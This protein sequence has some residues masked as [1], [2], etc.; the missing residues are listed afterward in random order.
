MEAKASGDVPFKTR[1]TYSHV[2]RIAAFLEQGRK[3]PDNG[4]DRH[5]PKRGGKHIPFSFQSLPSYQPTVC[6]IERFQSRDP[7]R[8]STREHGFQKSRGSQRTDRAKDKLTLQYIGDAD[9]SR[10]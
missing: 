1:D 4:P 6:R 7:C 8:Q 10:W 3:S 9:V 5:D 2:S